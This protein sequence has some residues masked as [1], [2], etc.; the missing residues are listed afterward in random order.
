M[1]PRCCAVT[2]QLGLERSRGSRDWVRA[3][4]PLNAARTKMG[5]TFAC[6]GSRLW[7]KND[8][9]AK[10]LRVFWGPSLSVA[11]VVSQEQHSTEACTKTKSTL[12]FSL[13]S[14]YS[15][16]QTATQNSRLL[17]LLSVSDG[18]MHNAHAALILFCG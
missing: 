16:T 3:V 6:A 10:T 17:S 5:T 8:Q 2:T 18:K 11:N 1:M 15:F 12:Q 13:I 7:F 4:T 14:G 9:M